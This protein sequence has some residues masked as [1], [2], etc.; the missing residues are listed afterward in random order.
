MNSCSIIFN[1]FLSWFSCYR[2]K[3]IVLINN[4]QHLHC[5]STF[6]WSPCSL[7]YYE[8]RN[9]EKNSSFSH[10]QCTPLHLNSY[11]SGKG[12]PLLCVVVHTRSTFSHTL[13]KLLS[14]LHL[15]FTSNAA[16][17]LSFLLFPGHANPILFQAFFSYLQVTLGYLSFKVSS[18]K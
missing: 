3:R 9:G 13:A 4:T 8:N 16:Y 12:N 5:S 15:W 7:F 11:A 6:G 2:W 1:S 18:L 10:Q 14:T 17:C